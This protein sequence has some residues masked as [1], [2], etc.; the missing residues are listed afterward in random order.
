MPCQAFGQGDDSQYRGAIQGFRE[1]TG[2]AYIQ[3]L[4]FRLQMGIQHLSDSY[5]PAGV[6]A[7]K[8][9]HEYARFFRTGF[10]QNFAAN[11]IGICQTIIISGGHGFTDSTI[12][13]N[14]AGY[15]IFELDHQ[16]HH[17][18]PVQPLQEGA[19]TLADG[20]QRI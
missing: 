5:R 11:R 12:R 10:D 20:R 9:P 18:V 15:I 19:D 14:A 16:A 2:V 17:F 6:G 7:D 1:N 8:G 4:D 3:A 13:V